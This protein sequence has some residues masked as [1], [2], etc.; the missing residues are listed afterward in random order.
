[1][2]YYNK[3]DSLG[4]IIPVNT[5]AYNSALTYNFLDIVQNNKLSYISKVDNNNSS[6]DSSDWMQISVNDLGVTPS[7]NSNTGIL[8]WI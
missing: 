6:L 5:G 3:I 7:L 2:L 4:R 8:S 1:M